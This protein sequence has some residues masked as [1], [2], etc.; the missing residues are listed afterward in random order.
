MIL[1]Q[2]SYMHRYEMGRHCLEWNDFQHGIERCICPKCYDS[3]ADREGCA[4]EGHGE[5][6]MRIG[7]WE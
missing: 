4:E 6:G 5:W 1:S 7:E 3:E 2:D